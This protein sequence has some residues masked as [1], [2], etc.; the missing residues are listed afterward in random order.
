MDPTSATCI[1][2]GVILLLVSWIQLIITSFNKDYSW[3]LTTLFLP[4]LSYIYGFF[5]WENARSSIALAAIG[6]TLILFGL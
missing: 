5:S 2:F 4:P 3:G 6:C 1:T